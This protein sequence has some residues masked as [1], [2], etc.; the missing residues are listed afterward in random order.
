VTGPLGSAAAGFEFGM[1]VVQLVFLNLHCA[2]GTV[3]S[4]LEWRTRHGRQDFDDEEDA[5]VEG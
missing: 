1:F 4:H 2:Q 3:P 5:I